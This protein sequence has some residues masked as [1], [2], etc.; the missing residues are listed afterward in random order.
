PTPQGEGLLHPIPE[1]LVT[2][3]ADDPPVV[4]ADQ[5]R[6]RPGLLV[7]E[8]VAGR[9]ALRGDVPGVGGGEL[10]EPARHRVVEDLRAVLGVALL[11]GVARGQ[12][13]DRRRA[14]LRPRRQVRERVAEELTLGRVRAGEGDAGERG[15]AEPPREDGHADPPT[16]GLPQPPGRAA[17]DRGRRPGPV[18]RRAPGLA[19]CA[20]PGTSPG[21]GRTARPRRGG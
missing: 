9:R 5:P 20:A 12:L 21:A 19:R 3:L 8:A 2:A 7:H 16:P 15:T 14:D 13:P 18:V 1:P 17:P 10:D 6:P 11:P 4:L